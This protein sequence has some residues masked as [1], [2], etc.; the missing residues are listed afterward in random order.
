MQL[1]RRVGDIIAANLND[2]VDRFEDPEVML[3]QAIRE[4]ETMIEGATVAAARAVAGERLLSKDLADHERR[5]LNWRAAAEDAVARDE[6]AQARRAL[7]HAHEHEA[8][9]R[10]LVEQRSSAGQTAETLCGQV[11]AMRAKLA[12]ARGKL[13]SL[14]ARRQVVEAGRSLRGTACQSPRGARGF[15]RFERMRRRVEQAEAETKAL[16]ELCEDLALDPDSEA[17]SRER[18]R[19]VEADLAEIRERLQ[20][21]PKP[22]G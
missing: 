11:N 9:A 16:G 5:V 7:A 19:R 22:Q 21:V 18:A 3:R 1:F 8:L 17:V 15:A 6:D 4:M 12:E 10:V 2:L 14:S 20:R 13:A